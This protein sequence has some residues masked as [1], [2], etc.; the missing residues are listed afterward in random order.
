[1]GRS[2]L[3]DHGTRADVCGQDHLGEHALTRDIRT[4]QADV[5]DA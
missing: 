4:E 2:Y 5:R 3:D 1:M